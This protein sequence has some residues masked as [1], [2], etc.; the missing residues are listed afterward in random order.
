MRRSRQGPV[1]G[2]ALGHGERMR[3][4]CAGKQAGRQAGRQAGAARRR[5]PHRGV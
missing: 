5:C 1:G 3:R 4:A 2:C